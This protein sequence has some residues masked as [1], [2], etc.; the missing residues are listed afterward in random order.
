MTILT[1]TNLSSLEIPE[2]WAGMKIEGLKEHHNEK[3]W[4]DH[5]EPVGMF[6]SPFY[7]PQSV[8]C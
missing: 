1:F 6:S 2:L 3:F 7:L 8:F 5:L 4:K